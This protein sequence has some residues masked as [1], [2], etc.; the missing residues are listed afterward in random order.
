MNTLLRLPLAVGVGIAVLLAPFTASAL[1]PPT[2]TH[3]GRLFDAGGAP[4]TGNFDIDFALYDAVDA[5]APIWMETH[6][7]DIDEGYFSVALGRS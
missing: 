4:L 6:S 5:V 3:Q 2:V 1:V 7:I